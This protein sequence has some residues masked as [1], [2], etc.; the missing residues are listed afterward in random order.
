MYI[1]KKIQRLVFMSFM[2]L[3]NGTQKITRI[4][5]SNSGI[6]LYLITDR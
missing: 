5:N 4:K 6:N 1:M 3:L 2:I